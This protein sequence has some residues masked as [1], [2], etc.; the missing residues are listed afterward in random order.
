MA[1]VME[2]LNAS[3]THFAESVHTSIPAQSGLLGK[4]LEHV[5]GWTIFFTICAIA[6]VYDQSE[7]KTG[8]VK[9]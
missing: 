9:S 6:V 5:N 4:A 1:S 3:A 2:G 7:Q 8:D